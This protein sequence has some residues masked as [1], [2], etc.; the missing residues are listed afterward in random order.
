MDKGRHPNVIRTWAVE[1]IRE[2]PPKNQPRTG[3]RRVL[4][5]SPRKS[6]P[7]GGSGPNRGN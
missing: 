6:P 5:R 3:T 1:R 4:S 7:A 2:Q